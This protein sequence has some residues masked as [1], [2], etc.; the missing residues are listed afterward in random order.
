MSTPDD[1]PGTERGQ[2]YLVKSILHASQV[3]WASAGTAPPDMI[4]AARTGIT[5]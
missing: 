2:V 5:A 1:L 3:L 4:T